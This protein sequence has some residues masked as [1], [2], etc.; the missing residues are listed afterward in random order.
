MSDDDGAK[1]TT[2][3]GAVVTEVQKP[4]VFANP[5]PQDRLDTHAHL[6][7]FKVIVPSKQDGHPVTFFLT[8]RS[9]PADLKAAL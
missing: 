3:S 6:H 9:D 4:P 8:T 2:G 7:V 5:L 1:R